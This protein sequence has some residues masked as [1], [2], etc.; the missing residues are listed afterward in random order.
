MNIPSF[1]YSY[2]LNLGITVSL[3]ET[4]T[5]NILPEKFMRKKKKLPNT[6]IFNNGGH[7]EASQTSGVG[8]QS[9]RTYWMLQWAFTSREQKEAFSPTESGRV[10]GLFLILIKMGHGYNRIVK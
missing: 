8:I 3:K 6:E 4:K 2:K 1:S 10:W 7:S 5:N 9:K